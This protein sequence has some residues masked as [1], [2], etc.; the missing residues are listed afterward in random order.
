MKRYSTVVFASIIAI[1]FI[2]AIVF[3]Y[4]TLITFKDFFINFQI[5]ELSRF[6]NV[7]EKE[8]RS[9]IETTGFNWPTISKIS[10]YLDSLM[11]LRISI[12]DTTGLVIV[13]TREDVKQLDN[14]IT[15]PE[16]QDALAKGEGFSH[17]FSKSVLAEYVYYAKKLQLSN[18]TTLIARV[19]VPKEN[20][21]VFFQ[22]V[23]NKILLIFVSLFASIVLLSYILSRTL[24]KPIIELIDA[25]KKV[26][27]GDFDVHLDERG[28]SEISFLKRN[29][30]EMVSE[31]KRSLDQVLQQRNFMNNLINSLDQSV[32]IIDF[33][34]N[35]IFANKNYKSIVISGENIPR[36]TDLPSEE[37]I[38]K[39]INE[40]IKKGKYTTIE[41]NKNEKTYLST[42]KP[43][44]DIEQIIHLLYDISPLKRV[45]HIKRDLVANVSHELRTPLT[46]LKGYI[47][48]LEEEIPCEQFRY[49][50]TIKKN[51]ERIIRI[52]DDL[53]SLVS[54]EDVSVKL[55]VSDVDLCRLVQQIVPTFKQK[56]E[57]KKLSLEVFCEENFPII[58][59]DGFR[60]EQV[61]INLVDNAIKYSEKGTIKI[62]LLKNDEESVKIIVSDEGIGIPKEHQDRIFERFY[63]VNKSHSRKYG[64][65]GLGLSIVKHIILL[66]DG[67]IQVESEVGKGTKFIIYLPTN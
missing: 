11:N 47:E 31:I 55:D 2:F 6:N 27:E 12:I 39:Q 38:V 3:I 37:P 58:R 63:T 52:V 23:Q 18:G 50:E 13:D 42:V 60:L 41:I 56:L 67:N 10:T 26:A 4:Q 22:E 5:K 59:A 51:T 61:F 19:S 7:V 57:Q 21:N 62:Y 64:G 25:S 45:E 48:T 8:L 35:I 30:N 54:L 36:I 43:L 40:A 28:E 49:L 29:F 65:T 9:I 17:R 16:I 14:H 33:D 66:H 34:F 32:A 20:L 44:E 15:R 24:T 1:V 53:L 46:A